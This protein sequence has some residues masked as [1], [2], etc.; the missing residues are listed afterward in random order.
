MVTLSP[1]PRERQSSTRSENFLRGA[2]HERAARPG[3]TMKPRD[4]ACRAKPSCPQAGA[5]SA[6]A[7]R[8]CTRSCAPTGTTTVFSMFSFK[9]EQRANS[10]KMLARIATDCRPS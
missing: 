9:P 1:A 4:R 10:S 7:T 8:S 2:P 5:R 3:P 6:M